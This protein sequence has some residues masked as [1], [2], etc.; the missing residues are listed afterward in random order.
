MGAPLDRLLPG[1]K[2]AA[3]GRRGSL[4]RAEVVNDGI[5]AST[6]KVKVFFMDT[7]EQRLVNEEDLRELSKH[8]ARKSPLVLRTGLANVAPPPQGMSLFRTATIIYVEFRCFEKGN[9]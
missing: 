8:I 1:Q 3:P 7:R 5:N 2:V 4:A 6:G 9:V